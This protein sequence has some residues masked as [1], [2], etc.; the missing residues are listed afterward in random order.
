MSRSLE[1]MLVVG[2]KTPDCDMQPPS[3]SHKAKAQARFQINRPDWKKPQK[4]NICAKHVQTFTDRAIDAGCEIT[5][6]KEY[7]K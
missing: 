1:E 7:A 3:G 4:A 6:I 5:L 2:P